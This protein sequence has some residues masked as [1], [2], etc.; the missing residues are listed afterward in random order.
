[1]DAV[2]CRSL[3]IKF[4][5]NLEVNSFYVQVTDVAEGKRSD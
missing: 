4:R 1:M 2:Y 3:D 5:S